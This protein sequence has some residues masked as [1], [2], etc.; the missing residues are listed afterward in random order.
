MP[1]PSTSDRRAQPWRGGG[2]DGWTVLALLLLVPFSYSAWLT[3]I[4]FCAA[5][6]RH[7][8]LVASALFFPVGVVHGIVVW[9]GG[10]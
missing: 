1:R 10:W 9:C 5:G 3:S 7:P 8:L 2:M 6:A 4:V